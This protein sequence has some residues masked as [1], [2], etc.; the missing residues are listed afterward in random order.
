MNCVTF[1]ETFSTDCQRRR[2][3]H[4]PANKSFPACSNC[5][6]M[7]LSCSSSQPRSMQLR[8]AKQACMSASNSARGLDISIG[9]RKTRAVGLRAGTSAVR[10]TTD[11]IKKDRLSR[12]SR[13]VISARMFESGPGL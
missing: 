3:P 8:S 12:P 11:E 6:L 9:F 5:T 1:G 7:P 2:W 10:V 13:D 4:F